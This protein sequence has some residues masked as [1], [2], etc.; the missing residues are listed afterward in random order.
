MRTACKHRPTAFDFTVSGPV[1]FSVA[2]GINSLGVF[3]EN[4][5]LLN[6][7]KNIFEIFFGASVIVFE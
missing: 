3:G 6:L 2:F 7:L 4:C 1:G 5:G